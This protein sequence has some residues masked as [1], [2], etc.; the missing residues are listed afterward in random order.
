[1]Y[2]EDTFEMDN[3]RRYRTDLLFPMPSILSG[4]GTLFNIAGNYYTYNYS[5]TPYVA[6]KRALESDWG[7]V[8]EDFRTVLTSLA[9]ME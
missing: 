7:M 2:S 3:T 5:P 9:E 6:D 4:L 1:M 8:G